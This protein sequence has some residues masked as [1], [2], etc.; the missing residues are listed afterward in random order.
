MLSVGI[1]TYNEEVRIA[2]TL[3]AVKELADE[4]VIIDSFSTDRTVEIAESY[5]AKVLQIKWPGYGQQ[6]NNVIQKG[7]NHWLLFMMDESD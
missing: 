6:K 1:I 4:I 5:G 7:I 2:R 3:E